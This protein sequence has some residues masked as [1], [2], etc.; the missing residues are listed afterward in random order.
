MGFKV[1]YKVYNILTI[2]PLMN[3]KWLMSPYQPT[4]TLVYNL[5]WS[6]S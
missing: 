3:T 4:I 5:I 1:K 2:L 6:I